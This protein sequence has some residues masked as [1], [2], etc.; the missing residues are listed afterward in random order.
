MKGLMTE[1]GGVPGALFKGSPITSVVDS[2]TL[3]FPA[4]RLFTPLVFN[5]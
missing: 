5:R 2:V 3:N 4:K 1:C